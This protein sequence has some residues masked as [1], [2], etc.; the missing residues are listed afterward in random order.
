L[1]ANPQ[2]PKL[3]YW[4]VFFD[5]EESFCE[6]WDQCHIPNPDDLSKPLPDNTYGSRR[7]VSQ[8]RS[9]NALGRVRA[10]IL[11]DMRVLKISTWVAT[12]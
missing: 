6:D 8:L 5:G 12:Q 1:G 9:S 7:Y 3:T 2:K 4:L 11:L 10:L